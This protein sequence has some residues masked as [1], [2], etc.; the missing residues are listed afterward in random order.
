[1]R[2]LV[3]IAAALLFSGPAA[4][5]AESEGHHGMHHAGPKSGECKPTASV[6]A[7]IDAMDVMHRDM[8]ITYIGDADVDFVKGM[9]PHHQGAVDMVDVLF[10]YGKDAELRKLGQWMKTNQQIEIQNM[11][12]WLY[13]HGHTTE[14]RWKG[15]RDAGRSVTGKMCPVVAAYE[16]ANEQMHH[17]MHIDYTGNA[18]IDFVRGMIPHHQGAVDMALVLKKHGK[19]PELQK[20]ADDIIRSQRQEI[21]WMKRW[22]EAHGNASH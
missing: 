9:I 15:G 1:M 3:F 7:Y 13:T 22:L 20:L 19:N 2:K 4:I 16:A 5:A 14:I 17:A 12:R 18:D 6:Q 21:A 8:D 11:Q 10:K